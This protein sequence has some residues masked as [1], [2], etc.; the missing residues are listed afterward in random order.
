MDGVSLL[1]YTLSSTRDNNVEYSTENI[2]EYYEY[3]YDKIYNDILNPPNS[4]LKVN[5][6]KK[7]CNNSFLV[8]GEFATRLMS[9]QPVEMIEVKN[10]KFQLLI[11]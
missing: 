11:Y 8:Q 2:M 7:V 9:T 10:G 5:S 6:I 3:D 1:I 4:Y